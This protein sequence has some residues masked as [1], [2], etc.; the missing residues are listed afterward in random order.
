MTK[1]LNEKKFTFCF[2]IDNTICKTLGSNYKN[3][4]PKKKIINKINKLYSNGH[5][6]KIYSARYMG[7]NKDNIYKANI[8]GY[9]KTYN[10]LVNWGLKFHKLSIN[11][12][13]S[14]IYIDD[15]AFG[16][17]SNWYKKFL[18]LMK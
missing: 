14:D 5:T 18:K 12:P 6:I 8:Q 3:S 4:K 17:K 10:Q 13:S 1:I 15:K 9:K 2:D 11:K 7:R 16:Y